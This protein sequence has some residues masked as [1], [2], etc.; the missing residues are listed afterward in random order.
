M[1]EVSYFHLSSQYVIPVSGWIL[2]S[3]FGGYLIGHVPGA[4]FTHKFSAK[5]IFSLSILFASVCNAASPLFLKYG[6]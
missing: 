1:K 4:T 3:F 2:S 5:W 6:I